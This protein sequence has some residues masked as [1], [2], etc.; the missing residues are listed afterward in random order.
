MDFQTSTIRAV[1][2]SQSLDSVDSHL[3]IILGHNDRLIK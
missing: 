2:Y 1:V 3:D